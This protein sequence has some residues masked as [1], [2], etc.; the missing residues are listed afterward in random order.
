MD[1]E[2]NLQY[3]LETKNQIKQAL[4]DKGCII[5]DTATFRSYVDLIAA[6]NV[7]IEQQPASF[8]THTRISNEEIILK[9]NGVETIPMS[10]SIIESMGSSYYQGTALDGLPIVMTYY[11]GPSNTTIYVTWKSQVT[12]N[13]PGYWLD[14]SYYE[15]SEYEINIA[16]LL[17]DWEN[18]TLKVQGVEEDL[19]GGTSTESVPASL[20]FNGCYTNSN[21][22]SLTALTL[23]IAE[24]VDGVEQT[25]V[26]CVGTYS[27]ESKQL[28]DINGVNNYAGYCFNFGDVFMTGKTYKITVASFTAERAYHGSWHV[29]DDSAIPT[30]WV[31]EYEGI[32][33]GNLIYYTEDTAFAYSETITVEK[34]VVRYVGGSSAPV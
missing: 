3:L 24:I 13:T 31:E 32:T 21:V 17:V 29:F 2:N 26:T 14:N 33:V 28:L 15:D 7:V 27:T 4:I 18:R 8:A 20:T 6:L 12:P 34:D 9:V 11:C 10:L 25:P 23:N 1:L 22:G 16:T 19:S 30:A 5:E